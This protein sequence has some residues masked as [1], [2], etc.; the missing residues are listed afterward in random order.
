MSSIQPVNPFKSLER[1]DQAKMIPL[2]RIKCSSK[3]FTVRVFVKRKIN[4]KKFQGSI[5]LDDSLTRNQIIIIYTEEVSRVSYGSKFKDVAEGKIYYITNVCAEISY[6]AVD[7]PFVLR[8]TSWTEVIPCP[9]EFKSLPTLYRF[10]SMSSLEVD[11]KELIA[12]KRVFVDVIGYVQSKESSRVGSKIKKSKIDE[13]AIVSIQ[14]I[15]LADTENHSISVVFFGESIERYLADINVGD[16]IA[17][18]SAKISCFNRLSLIYSSVTYHDKDIEHLKQYRELKDWLDNNCTNHQNNS[19]IVLRSLTKQCY[20]DKLIST[21]IA[22]IASKIF[23]EE[24]DYTNDN[25]YVVDGNISKEAIS[26]NFDRFG[27]PKCYQLFKDRLCN[28]CNLP[29]CRLLE[30][31]FTVTDPSDNDISSLEV[32]ARDEI[33]ERLVKMNQNQFSAETPLPHCLKIENNFLTMGLKLLEVDRWELSYSTANATTSQTTN[34]NSSTI[35]NSNSNNNSS[36]QNQDGVIDFIVVG[37]GNQQL[38][39]VNYN[40]DDLVVDAAASAAS[41]VTSTSIASSTSTTSTATAT[42]T[43]KRAKKEDLTVLTL[44]QLRQICKDMGLKHSLSKKTEIVTLIESHKAILEKERKKQERKEKKLALSQQKQQEQEQQQKQEQQKKVKAEEKEEEEVEESAEDFDDLKKYTKKKLYTLPYEELK[45]ICEDRRYTCSISTQRELA[46]FIYYKLQEEDARKK[47]EKLLSQLQQIKDENNQQP[48]Q[49]PLIVSEQPTQQQQPNIPIE[50]ISLT[51]N[52]VIV[53]KQEKRDLPPPQQQQPIAIPTE[54]TI[55]LTNKQEAETTE[56]VKKEERDLPQHKQHQHQQQVITNK[57]QKQQRPQPQHQQQKPTYINKNTNTTTT[58]TE[59]KLKPLVNSLSIDELLYVC[60]AKEVWVKGRVVTKS[61][62]LSA[63]SQINITKTSQVQ[64]YVDEFHRTKQAAKSNTYTL[65]TTK[66][67]NE[68]ASFK[69]ALTNLQSQFFVLTEDLKATIHSLDDPSISPNHRISQTKKLNNIFKDVLLPVQCENSKDKVELENYWNGLVNQF[70]SV[71]L[72]TIGAL[73]SNSLANA[74]ANSIFKYMSE[75]DYESLPHAVEL[76]LDRMLFNQE[77]LTYIKNYFHN[78]G[79]IPYQISDINT[80]L[81]RLDSQK[82]SS[83][84]N[85]ITQ[86]P[87]NFNRTKNLIELRTYLTIQMTKFNEAL[88]SYNQLDKQIR[89]KCVF[90]F[91]ALFERMVILGRFDDS[92]NFLS[93][94]IGQLASENVVSISGNNNNNHFVGENCEAIGRR[95]YTARLFDGSQH[96]S[97]DACQSR[98]NYQPHSSARQT[99]AYQGALRVESLYEVWNFRDQRCASRHGSRVRREHLDQRCRLA[100]SRVLGI[101]RCAS[102]IKVTALH[103]RQGDWQDCPDPRVNNK[104]AT[105]QTSMISFWLLRQTIY[106]TNSSKRQYITN[107]WDRSI[108]ANVP[109]SLGKTNLVDTA[110][111]GSDSTWIVADQRRLHSLRGRHRKIRQQL[112][113]VIGSSPNMYAATGYHCMEIDNKEYLLKIFQAMLDKCIPFNM[114][115]ISK[116]CNYFNG[117]NDIQSLP[118]QSIVQ[119]R[120]I[121]ENKQSNPGKL[122]GL[123]NVVFNDML[124]KNELEA[125]EKLFNT[126]KELKDVTCYHLAIR[127]FFAKHRELDPFGPSAYCAFDQLEKFLGIDEVHKQK[128]FAALFDYFHENQQSHHVVAMMNVYEPYFRTFQEVA[129]LNSILKCIKSPILKIEMFKRFKLVS[130]KNSFPKQIK[131][132]ILKANEIV[133]DPE[134]DSKLSEMTFR[135]PQA[136]NPDIEDLINNILVPKL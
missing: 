131:S 3:Q 71:L 85:D 83:N 120:S 128:Y 68:S 92:L 122:I 125:A 48:Q 10:I 56:P 123:T 23:K 46:K 52:P 102:P 98:T 119:I 45:R 104:S 78:R 39:N 90:S 13:T 129:L 30:I 91:L 59:P 117:S 103:T 134:V 99:D 14:T 41:S 80:E 79:T 97:V 44:A 18:K 42:A 40:D 60:K 37:S 81:A 75:S 35:L 133:M 47:T 105:D 16:I 82:N 1:I 55:S 11:Y 87:S 132:E 36:N 53:A 34:D 26:L 20:R 76:Y 136:L 126:T 4:L 107:S 113:I 5:L 88:K 66:Y 93:E 118:E 95:S 135:E 69:T 62:L 64:E 43:R 116:V 114:Y 67:T 21:N 33:A 86:Q 63:L 124:K 89:F 15:T 70:N 7:H 2:S 54:S 111:K 32:N 12:Y 22:S 110:L 106:A 6:F 38:N 130:F 28:V 51:T 112:P 109:F 24:H 17:I 65:A 9:E 25:L 77:I 121:Y 127:L 61:K 27:C 100:R 101:D 94:N 58:T 115:F 19:N 73:S 96:S 84:N 49:Q 29:P 8:C 31:T 74:N 57:Y 50:T 108:I 72:S